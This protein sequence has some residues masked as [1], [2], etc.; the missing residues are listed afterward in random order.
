LN[1]RSE[2]TRTSDQQNALHTV[3]RR[4]VVFR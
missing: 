3:D 4:P 1:R 2:L